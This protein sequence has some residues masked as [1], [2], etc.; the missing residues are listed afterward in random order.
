M[1]NYFSFAALIA[2]IIGISA[3]T[4]N[5]GGTKAVV[6]RKIRHQVQLELDSLNNTLEHQL[7]TSIINDSGQ[8]LVQ[9]YFLD[10]RKQYKDIEFAIEYFHSYIARNINGPALPEIEVEEHIAI[11]PSGFQML[12]ACFFPKYDAGNK[13]AVLTELKKITTAVNSVKK[14]WSSI[15]IRDDQVFDALRQQLVRVMTMGI[16]GF[17]TPICLQS[18]NELPATLQSLK[19]VMEWYANNNNIKHKVI[20]HKI[21]RAIAF[22]KAAHDFNSFNRITFITDYMNPITKELILFQ[23]ECKVVILNNVYAL[24]GSMATLFDS[25]S[26]RAEYFIPSYQSGTTPQKTALGKLLS[27]AYIRSL[28]SFNTRFD[29]YM[30]GNYLLLSEDEQQGFNLFMGKAKCGTCHF[31][32]TF[33]GMVPLSFTYTE[34][35][36]LD[37]PK[38]ALEKELDDDSGRYDIHEITVF[39][40]AFK[41]P[42]LRNIALTA[43]Y[44]HNGVYNTL[45]QVIEFYNKG[46]GIG[47]AF[48]IDNQTLP[49]NKLALSSKEKHQLI[50]FLRSL[51]DSSNL[52][53]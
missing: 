24:N 39:K 34:S 4:I 15:S 43:P 27:A 19:K 33:N 3:L 48:E 30:R 46:G 10:S 5:F 42:T 17:D 14:L 51:S 31:M 38:T 12:E 44:L 22:A 52:F 37:V 25:N 11:Q 23:K 9:R 7:K 18:I 35:E 1:R 32:P 16:T 28:T 26:I 45:E 49:K 21:E 13:V 40:N 6:T 8:Q 36:V 50:S 2:A 53:K 29:R 41:T 47:L 20:L